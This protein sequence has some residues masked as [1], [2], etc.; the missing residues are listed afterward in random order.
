MLHTHTH[1][2]IHI[3]CRTVVNG[4]RSDFRDAA[5][6]RWGLWIQYPVLSYLDSIRKRHLFYVISKMVE[7]VG[8]IFDNICIAEVEQ[9]G[10]STYDES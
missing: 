9:Y 6:Y 3:Q 7:S 4:T 8:S 10:V 2:H 5:T 1:T